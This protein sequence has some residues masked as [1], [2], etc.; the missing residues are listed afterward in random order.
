MQGEEM[1]MDGET[2]WREKGMQFMLLFS[3]CLSSCPPDM[4]IVLIS[5]FILLP[6][7]YCFI[8]C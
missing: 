4:G 7:A 5:Y 1:F 8:E 6:V 3:V 2:K